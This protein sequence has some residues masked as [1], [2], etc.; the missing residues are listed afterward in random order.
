MS[1]ATRTAVFVV[2]AV[3]LAGLLGWGLA[4]LPSFGD[5]DGRYSELVSRIAVGERHATDIVATVV[6]DLRGID[7]LGE[8]LILF[9]AA[10]GV[11]TLLRIQRG[12]TEIEADP[13]EGRPVGWS[14]SARAVCTALVGPVVVLGIY[15]VSHGHLTPGGGFQGGIV[16]LAAFLLL[17]LGGS[18]LR[19][20]EP[21]SELELAE[22]VG[23]VGFAL[24]G[25]GGLIIAGAY[26]ENFVDLGQ[27]ARPWSGGTIPLLNLAVA[28]EVLG[29]SLAIVSELLDR[30]ML[31]RRREE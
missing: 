9:T 15:V 26:L 14:A 30:K 28:I 11:L 23:I 13:D 27:V 4:G 21:I 8:E 6:F 22:G 25:L 3:T 24:I 1:R 16:L 7:T 10:T 2:S 29:A 20:V 5:F 19:D 17:Y 12:E 18:R 31:S